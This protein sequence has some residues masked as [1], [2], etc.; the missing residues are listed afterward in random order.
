VPA[1][2]LNLGKAYPLGYHYFRERLHKAFKSQAGLTDEE[3]IQ[4]GIKRAEFVKKGM[5][6]NQHLLMRLY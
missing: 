1:E 5:W 4:Q 2:L 6:S 3:M